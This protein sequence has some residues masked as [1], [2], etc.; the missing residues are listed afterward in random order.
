MMWTK[1]FGFSR[2]PV[3]DYDSHSSWVGNPFNQP[4]QI[5]S[6]VRVLVGTAKGAF[7]LTADGKR[8]DWKIEGPHFAGWEM[9]HLKGSPLN[10]DRIY[11]SQT[12]GWFGQVIQR[13]DDGGKTW[14]VQSTAILL[15][16]ESRRVSGP[17]RRRRAHKKSTIR[18]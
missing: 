16:H 7:I 18:L 1:Y 6:K 10:P 3:L 8:A 9:Y 4:L 5:M 14:T 13:S 2:N 12:S 15:P 17:E 11:A